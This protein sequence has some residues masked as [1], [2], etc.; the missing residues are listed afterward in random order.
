MQATY[1]RR[2]TLVIIEYGGSWP[3]WLSPDSG[4]MAVVAQHYEGPAGSLLTQ[5]ASRLTRL[6]GMGWRCESIVLVSNGRSDSDALAARSVLAR[7]L[8]ARLAQARSGRLVL[9][10]NGAK[11]TR[12]VHCLVGLASA[13][14]DATPP[15]VELA[16]RI[17]PYEALRSSAYAT[18]PLAEAS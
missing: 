10:L 9:S 17:G 3:S 13:L 1:W 5:V 11:S 8:L 12:A 4:D 15:G 16:L 2:A 18:Q 6:E 7:G 14:D